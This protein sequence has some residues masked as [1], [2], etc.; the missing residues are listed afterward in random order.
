M[1]PQK[2]AFWKIR[3][4]ISMEKSVER[5][6]F[7]IFRK[8]VRPPFMFEWWDLGHIV[9]Q[10]PVWVSRFQEVTGSCHH[11]YQV[12]LWLGSIG[13]P[14]VTRS[15]WEAHHVAPGG[16]G[17]PTLWQCA[18]TLHCR[19]FPYSLPDHQG[20]HRSQTQLPPY[21]LPS[22]LAPSPQAVVPLYLLLCTPSHLIETIETPCMG[23]GV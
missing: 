5:G 22:H 15:R 10:E 6:S 16:A 19:G 11:L 7:L 4:Y 12:T 21:L 13:A 2:S 14:N 17:T 1:S 9:K 8:I 3:V 23:E 20:A 18:A